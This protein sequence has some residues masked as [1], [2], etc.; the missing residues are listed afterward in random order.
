MLETRIR[1]RRQNGGSCHNICSLWLAHHLCGRITTKPVLRLHVGSL[2][3]CVTPTG[4]LLVCQPCSHV[5][6]PTVLLDMQMAGRAG[7]PAAPSGRAAAAATLQTFLQFLQELS[8]S[9]ASGRVVVSGHG[10]AAQAKYVLLDSGSKFG[11]LLGL[12]RSVVLT[13]GTL[14]PLELLTAQL[15][16]GKD[17]G[18]IRAF[19]CGHVVPAERVLA[20]GLGVGPRSRRIRLTHALRNATEMLDECGGVLVNVCRVAP[21]GVVAFVPSFDFLDKLRSRCGASCCKLSTAVQC[22]AVILVAMRARKLCRAPEVGQALVL[23]MPSKFTVLL[24][25]FNEPWVSYDPCTVQCR[26]LQTLPY[27]FSGD[28]VLHYRVA[29]HVGMRFVR[30]SSEIAR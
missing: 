4:L 20:V 16:G 6:K 28:R 9:N 10:P 12:A 25:A 30:F 5:S 21:Q 19:Q 3:P 11:G 24:Y 7:A 26:G 27:R 23:A 1:H 15:C 29:E 13:S 17:F 2:Q 18:R 8:N 14:A 22:T